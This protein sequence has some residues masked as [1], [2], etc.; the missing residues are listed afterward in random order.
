MNLC[1]VVACLTSDRHTHELELHSNPL[2]AMLINRI[3]HATWFDNGKGAPDYDPDSEVHKVRMFW[4]TCIMT[5][6]HYKAY[7]IGLCSPDANPTVR[8]A[9][10]VYFALGVHYPKVEYLP[11]GTDSDSDSCSTSES[12]S[13]E[14]EQS[15][16][17]SHFC[18]PDNSWQDNF[19]DFR[20]I[21][22]VNSSS[23]QTCDLPW[24][25]SCWTE[26]MECD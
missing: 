4:L 12:S 23:E 18:E 1:I 19:F 22:R 8:R 14:E 9:M 13:D 24:F 6:A 11:G 25:P 20:K 16:Q 17:Y 26:A 3:Q 7:L 15:A 21:W 5:L 2:F 10:W